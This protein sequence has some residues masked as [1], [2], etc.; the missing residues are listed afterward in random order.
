MKIDWNYPEPRT[1][2]LGSWDRFIGP[3]ATRSEVLLI[4]IPALLAGI[5]VPLY[6]IYANL[7]WNLLQLIVATLAALDLVGGV[8]ANASSSTKRWYHRE[9]QG[10]KDHFLFTA[11]HII[12][13]FL[14]AWLFLSMDWV[15]FVAVA[16]YLLISAV[17]ILKTPLYLQR[18]LA[19][20]IFLGVLV[21]N[22]YILNSPV[23]LEWLVPVLFLKLIVAH[24]IRE[25]PYRPE[26]EA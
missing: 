14:V 11:I 16:S 12:Y 15:F 6:A 26:N 23:G 5:A 21:L 17:I 25:E 9:G 20:L 24:L 3:G 22:T 7:N 10:F 4:L 19:L 2:L 18:P 1:G 13:P 8:V